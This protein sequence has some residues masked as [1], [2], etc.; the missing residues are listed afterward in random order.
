MSN[1]INDVLSPKNDEEVSDLLSKGGSTFFPTQTF[2]EPKADL[3]KDG[4]QATSIS[5]KN[6]VCLNGPCKH[7]AEVLVKYDSG[8]VDR[9]FF[10]V[11]RYCKA[12]SANNELMELTDSN[13][14]RCSLHEK[15]VKKPLA[16]LAVVAILTF[17]TL[18]GIVALGG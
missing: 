6:F 12:L 5:P 16:V 8:N 15:K 4:F 11:R 14:Y 1:R 2:L 3:G 9:E 17:G 7:Y 10:Q 18:I 13:I